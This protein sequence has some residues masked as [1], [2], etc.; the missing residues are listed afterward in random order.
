MTFCP[1]RR[2]RDILLHSRKQLNHLHSRDGHS[3]IVRT[4]TS[5]ALHTS[6]S[7]RDHTCVDTDSQRIDCR[8]VSSRIWPFDHVVQ[9]VE[10]QSE[11]HGNSTRRGPFTL[12]HIEK[13]MDPDAG[14]VIIG[15]AAFLSMFVVVYVCRRRT[16]L[17]PAPIIVVVREDPG[18]PQPF[19]PR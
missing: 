12:S 19:P 5:D 14:A 11:W 8:G 15:L 4:V 9:R 17:P 13:L 7:L 3:P 16:D 1:M 6:C 2:R 10:F 18:D